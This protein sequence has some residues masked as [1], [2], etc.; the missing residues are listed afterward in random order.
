LRLPQKSKVLLLS[1]VD[2]A[3]GWREGAPGRVLVPELRKRFPELTAIELT[4][5]STAAELDLVRAI[6]RRSDA[7]VAATYV[8]AASAS[9]RMNLAPAQQE[10][11]GALAKEPARP[12]VAIAFG[13][14]YV[15]GAIPQVPALML[16]FDVGDAPEAAAVRALCGEAP[17]GGTLPITIPGLFAFGH[18]L[19]R[20]A[21]A[22]GAPTR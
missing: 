22:P 6:A 12:L 4:D 17:I 15:A 13:N 18:G 19:T 16:A 14:P 20:T 1:L 7:V 8:R 11:L 21:V 2:Y 10:L 3:S 5:R 9:G